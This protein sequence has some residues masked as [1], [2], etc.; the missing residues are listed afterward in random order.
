[1]KL[2]FKCLLTG[3]FLI[4]L[5]T[6]VHAIPI[7]VIQSTSS[8]PI[9]E[10]F[11]VPQAIYDTFNVG[12][13]AQIGESFSGQTVTLSG[14]FGDSP[15][16]FES[17]SGTPSGPL[18][19][20]TPH[21][22]GVLTV[23]GELQGLLGDSLTNSLV[24]EGAISILFL[25]DQVEIGLDF[26]KGDGGDITLQFFERSGALFDEVLFTYEGSKSLTFRSSDNVSRFAGVSITNYDHRGI[27]IDNLRFDTTAA[28][29]EPA[30]FALLGIGLAGMAGYGVKRRRNKRAVVNS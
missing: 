29:P 6:P 27:G 25:S 17:V 22:G 20:Q 9:V 23:F 26:L 24:G 4:A 13:H 14:G 1:M 11:S 10:D 5:I 19:L 16:G 12:T 3:L 21:S 15:W 28:V 30:T 2:Y 7:N 18:S 8:L